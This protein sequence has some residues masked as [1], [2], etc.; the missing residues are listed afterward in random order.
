MRFRM[1]GCGPRGID[2]PGVIAM[3][4]GPRGGGWGRGWGGWD[5]DWGGHGSGRRGPSR[6]RAG[7]SPSRSRP[8]YRCRADR[9]RAF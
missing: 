7:Q 3:G 2:I 8:E 1:H 9:S 6:R 5:A 4:F